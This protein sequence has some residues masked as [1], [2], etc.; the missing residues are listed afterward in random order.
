MVLYQIITRQLRQKLNWK[1]LDNFGGKFEKAATEW[2]E[3]K[4]SR[5]NGQVAKGNLKNDPI[6][7]NSIQGRAHF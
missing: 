5:D 1:I 4:V 2:N 6:L 7:V 3:E